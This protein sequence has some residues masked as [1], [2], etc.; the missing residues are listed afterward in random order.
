MKL[1][2]VA[3]VADGL[4]ATHTAGVIHRDVKPG[5][6]LYAGAVDVRRRILPD[7]S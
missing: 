4:Q 5:N 6:I 7:L 3:Q 1:E 2:I